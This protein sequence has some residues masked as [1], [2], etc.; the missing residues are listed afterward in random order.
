MAVRRF[1]ARPGM[2]KDQLWQ[3]SYVPDFDTEIAPILRRGAAYPWVS[4]IPPHA[5]RFEFAKLADPDPAFNG[6]RQF[7]LAVLRPPSA[8]D[9]L[10][11]PPSTGQDQTDGRAPGLTM[12]PYLAGDNAFYF[13]A[14]TSKFLKLTDTQY[15]VLQQWARGTFRRGG[16][17]LEKPGEALDRAVLENC[18]GGG[19]SPGIEMTWISRNP[20]IY[21]EPFRLKHKRDVHPPLSL[22]EGLAGGLEPG[23]GCKYMALP[24]QAD[25]NEC[26]SQ[27][28]DLPM[29]PGSTSVTTRIVWWWPAQRPTAV[30]RR[31]PRRPGGRRQ[32]PW[33][34]TLDN[35]NA[36]DYVSFADDLTMV[37]R[38]SGLGFLY[39]YGTA[40]NPE[41]LLVDERPEGG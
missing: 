29:A 7:I 26:S 20:A 37:E 10:V 13:G 9:V 35:Q 33:V 14:P 6:L 15:F 30:W 12:M 40:E 8:P 28:V 22:G 18:V 2:Y 41:I 3:R 21:M 27:P 38:W 36:P 11:S 25:F 17:P 24:W 1:G 39:N 23:D 34:G 4:P 16:A 31:D 19:F 32:V 5:H